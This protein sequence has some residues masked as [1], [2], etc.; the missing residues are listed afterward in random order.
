MISKR[1]SIARIY[2]TPT[3][4]KFGVKLD[5]RIIGNIERSGDSFFYYGFPSTHILRPAPSFYRALLACVKSY[6]LWIGNYG[7]I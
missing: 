7:R 1:I 3:G 2:Q 5:N 6:V 4:D